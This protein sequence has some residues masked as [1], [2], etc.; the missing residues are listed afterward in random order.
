MR[1]FAVPSSNVTGSVG[2]AVGRGNGSGLVSFRY[3][4]CICL[5]KL[6]WFSGL[7][8]HIAGLDGNLFW[9]S[10][11]LP[12]PSPAKLL[13]SLY[14]HTDIAHFLFSKSNG[15]LLCAYNNFC[16][17]FC[18]H[19]VFVFIFK[20]TFKFSYIC[21]IVYWNCCCCSF[22]CYCCCWFIFVFIY[23]FGRNWV[24]LIVVPLVDLF[25]P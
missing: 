14:M 8:T 19:F 2:R 16:F 25:A 10:F 15:K 11:V 1:A 9:L 22:C 24:R 3:F 13:P 6:V 18:F 17:G 12:L 5:V 20:I 21:L 23:L 4:A 7:R